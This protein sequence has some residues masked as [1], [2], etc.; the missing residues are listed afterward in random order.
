[1]K[2]GAF[3]LKP[4]LSNNENVKATILE[5]EKAK[6]FYDTTFNNDIKERTLG[7]KFDILK[8]SFIFESL[9][10][11]RE[12]V[13]KTTISKQAASIFHPLGFKLPFV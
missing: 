7:I 8:E 5:T 13:T 2:A 3:R 4:S 11:E 10:F 12:E 6:S 9:T 1:M